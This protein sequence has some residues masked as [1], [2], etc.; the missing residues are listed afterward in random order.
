MADKGR[1][2]RWGIKD[3]PREVGGGKEGRVHSSKVIGHIKR[4]E[5]W[6]TGK[7]V[8]IR[9]SSKRQRILMLVIELIREG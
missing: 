3:E 1:R 9:N 6:R 5:G 7:W 2:K 8:K 4:K